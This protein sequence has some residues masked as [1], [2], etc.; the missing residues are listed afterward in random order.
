M[1]LHAPSRAIGQ[2]DPAVVV[3]DVDRVRVDVEQPY[4]LQ[5]IEQRV[6]RLRYRKV[7]LDAGRAARQR[8]QAGRHRQHVAQPAHRTRHENATRLR[9][10]AGLHPFAQPIQQRHR[11]CALRLLR[12]GSCRA[13]EDQTVEHI[14][15]AGVQPAQRQVRTQH[16][17]AGHL[18]RQPRRVAQQQQQPVQQRRVAAQHG[19]KHAAIGLDDLIDEC[20]AQRASG[21]QARHTLPEDLAV[22]GEVAAVRQHVHQLL[23]HARQVAAIGQQEGPVHQAQRGGRGLFAPAHEGVEVGRMHRQRLR[24][25]REAVS[26]CLQAQRRHGARLRHEIAVGEGAGELLE[27]VEPF[28]GEADPALRQPGHGLAQFFDKVA[29]LLAVDLDLVGQVR[30]DAVRH[31]DEHMAIAQRVAPCLRGHVEPGMKNLRMVVLERDAPQLER[32]AEVDGA[33][34][35]RGTLDEAERGAGRCEC[36]HGLVQ[37]ASRNTCS[38]VVFV[39]GVDAVERAAGA[40]RRARPPACNGCG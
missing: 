2:V 24:E 12:P 8:L 18:G 14:Q 20:I 5:A 23:V 37:A 33:V 6:E 4:P 39:S 30:P 13:E 17:K 35:R 36:G 22:D 7:D 11:L 31:R 28:L 19:A 16:G 9:R 40:R 21:M 1:R 26:P 34:R 27:S 15:A 3:R 29:R 38:A 32:R 25:A 10:T